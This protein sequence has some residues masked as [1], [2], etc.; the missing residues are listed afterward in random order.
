MDLIYSDNNFN[1][2][3]VMKDYTIDLAYGADENNFECEI[4]LEKHCCEQD[5]H[6]YIPQTEY[7]GIIDRIRVDVGSRTVTYAGRTWHGI[8]A[9]AI[10]CPKKGQSHYRI[11]GD[12]NA[13]VSEIIRYLGL[14]D[15]FVSDQSV[16]GI[17]VDYQFDRFTDAYSGLRK[18]LTGDEGLPFGKLKFNSNY[19]GTCTISVVDA[20]NYSDEEFDSAVDDF[21]VD[22]VFNGLNH[23]VACGIGDMEE[24]HVIH[25]SQMKMVL[26]RM[27]IL[28]NAKPSSIQTAT[29]PTSLMKIL[30]IISPPT[31]SN[32]LADMKL[33]NILM[34]V[35]QVVLQSI[36]Q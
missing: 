35:L 3:G 14:N 31:C 4:A 15:I 30:I 9:S 11:Q 2:I 10:I 22:K 33:Q 6:L 7:G 34:P 8:L 5:Y 25:V 13:C 36:S 29:R 24:R 27:F 16:S 18:M 28:T 23:V 21:D 19:N 26:F 32:A 1:D 20:L 17:D 12:A